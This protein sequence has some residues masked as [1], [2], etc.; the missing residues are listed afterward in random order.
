MPESKWEE[1][2]IEVLKEIRRGESIL[3]LYRDASQPTGSA[4]RWAITRDTPRGER[5]VL[6]GIGHDVRS[7]K[8]AVGPL[9]PGLLNRTTYASIIDRTDMRTVR[10]YYQAGGDIRE[11]VLVRPGEDLAQVAALLD[12]DPELRRSRGLALARREV[13][14]FAV[15]SP[16]SVPHAWRP[17]AVAIADFKDTH[18]C[19]V[20]YAPPAYYVQPEGRTPSPDVRFKTSWDDMP[21]E[22][23]W[24]SL[25]EGAAEHER[26]TLNSHGGWRKFY[27]KLPTVEA[28]HRDKDP[29]L[30]IKASVQDGRSFYVA[31]YSSNNYSDIIYYG[32]M[33]DPN[34]KTMEWMGVDDELLH[35]E[36]PGEIE[37][38]VDESWKPKRFSEDEELHPSFTFIPESECRQHPRYPL[39]TATTIG[40]L[41][42]HLREAQDIG[43][44]AF[45]GDDFDDRMKGPLSIKQTGINQYN[46]KAREMSALE[47][48]SRGLIRVGVK[49]PAAVPEE[50]R[51]YVLSWDALPDD[52]PCEITYTGG[53][54][55]VRLKGRSLS[56]SP[57]PS[58][59]E[60]VDRS[61]TPEAAHDLRPDLGPR[62]RM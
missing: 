56:M 15:D 34:T 55:Y 30:W 2:H 62:R 44:V 14:Q 21:Q 59:G 54:Y 49:D 10:R 12:V 13:I 33:A 1:E 47:L 60:P 57:D 8:E 35:W 46:Y 39:V 50:W 45:I 41:R 27:P 11:V 43:S 52:Q 37:L 9:V 38:I 32:L 18:P 19:R 5:T 3:R 23:D 53:M 20:I 24:D 6:E 16:D 42:S 25:R 61:P 22:P 17:Y 48:A 51:P 36:G 31:G 40:A 26:F 28:V 4:D 7:I 58:I 29:V